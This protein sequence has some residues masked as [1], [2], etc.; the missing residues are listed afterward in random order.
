MKVRSR[1]GGATITIL[2]RGHG[3]VTIYQGQGCVMM[4]PDEWSAV[5]EAVDI[6]LS[7]EQQT[8][9]ETE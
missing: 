6:V 3:N 1:T 9:R 4:T 8:A 2:P 7:K 5:K